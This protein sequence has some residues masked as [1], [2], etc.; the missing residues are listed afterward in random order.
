MLNMSPNLLFFSKKKIIIKDGFAPW[1]LLYAP[2]PRVTCA[3]S[4]AERA[5]QEQR[6][7][8]SLPQT[9]I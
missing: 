4:S 8:Y 9:L 1:K 7:V 3:G 2:P 6:A 5:R